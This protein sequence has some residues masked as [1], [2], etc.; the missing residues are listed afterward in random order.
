MKAWAWSAQHAY[1]HLQFAGEGKW[2]D[3]YEPAFEP[4]LD[5]SRSLLEKVLTSGDPPFWRTAFIESGP[6][7]TLGDYW[8]DTKDLLPVFG[9]YEYGVDTK[10]ALDKHPL[11][12]NLPDSADQLDAVR[13]KFLPACFIP[14]LRSLFSSHK[15]VELVSIILAD[16]HGGSEFNYRALYRDTS[17]CFTDGGK[18]D[19]SNN[20]ADVWHLPNVTVEPDP[21]ASKAG[22]PREFFWRDTTLNL[23]SAVLDPVN[24]QPLE[25][26]ALFR[27]ESSLPTIHPDTKQILDFSGVFQHINARYGPWPEGER[28]FFAHRA[29]VL[30]ECLRQNIR[31]AYECLIR[32][33]ISP[34]WDEITMA[35]W[36]YCFGE[37]SRGERQ[38]GRYTDGLSFLC[39]KASLAS[40]WT[41]C[42][43]AT[44]REDRERIGA[45][46]ANYCIWL[47]GVFGSDTIS[48]VESFNSTTFSS[49]QPTQFVVFARSHL[50]LLARARF[51]LTLATLLQPIESAFAVSAEIDRQLVK[52]ARDLAAGVYKIGHPLK[53]RMGPLRSS[54]KAI[55]SEGR[56]H[57]ALMQHVTVAFE[58]ARRVE[59]LGHLLDMISRAVAG[60]LGQQTFAVNGKDEW[61]SARPYDIRASLGELRDIV[62]ATERRAVDVPADELKAIEGVEI[63][64]WIP[65]SDEP[66]RPADFFY[67][68]MLMELITNASRRGRDDTNGRVDL[69]VR[70]CDI[71]DDAESDGLCRDCLVFSNIAMAEVDVSSLGIS[72]DR[73]Q[74]WNITE[75]GAVGGLFFVATCLK[76]TESGKLYT[77]VDRRDGSDTFHVGIRLTGMINRRNGGHPMKEG[78]HG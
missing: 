51:K 56:G 66:L 69:H 22:P 6:N 3:L 33:D 72:R 8:H 53:D 68:E 15:E 31:A 23:S 25:Y 71:P 28:C 19:L 65:G 59:S 11:S 77:R 37:L 70:L 75:T 67:R 50:G 39:Y 43:K 35:I 24:E 20:W 21:L 40:P 47:F 58:R 5:R 26:I 57:P 52:G 29:I 64:P 16:R 32:P 34:L 49:K 45:S 14:P 61:R 48:S 54:L 1:R 10:T 30:R 27:R 2:C 17:P 60:Q 13:S 78:Q 44:R 9:S 36:D 18:Q 74:S 76:A 41:R 12:S 62:N 55:Y 42:C 46:I 4:S 73:W 7:R 38:G 63:A